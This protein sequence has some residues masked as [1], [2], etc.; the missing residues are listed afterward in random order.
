M[1]DIDLL[2]KNTAE[3]L[4]AEGPDHDIVISSRI[5]IARNLQGFSYTPRLETR[6]QDEI[7]KRVQDILTKTPSMKSAYFFLYADLTELERQFLV[8]RHLVSLE[9]AVEKGHKAVSMTP[10]QEISVMI[11]EEDHLRM[12]AFQSGFNLK[13]AWHIIDQL[14]TEIERGGLDYAFDS[15]LGYLTACPT[16]AGTGLRA[17]C[18]VHIPGLVLTKQINKILQALTKLNLATRGL[19]GEGTQAIGDYFQ[20]SNQMTLGQ[21]EEEI[22]D[23]LVS[24]I[25]Q[26]TDHEREARQHLL[27]KKKQKFED[28]AWRALGI[29]KSARVISSTEATQYLSLVQLG[30]NM[31]IM[32]SALSR[33]ELHSLFLYIQPAHLQKMSGSVLNAQERD[34]LRAQVIREKLGKVSLS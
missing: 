18:M 5:R 32:T 10:N 20:F 14:D 7:I 16:N 8:E 4:R 25:R 27:D 19:Y 21:N 29:L 3:W 34:I 30:I 11:L 13:K 23:N 2:V 33:E 24:V 12:Q 1:S 22:I 15:R 26:I 6:E 9:H 28:P 31:G 17:S